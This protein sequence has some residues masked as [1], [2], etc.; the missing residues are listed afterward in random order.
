MGY[1]S[2]AMSVDSLDGDSGV[3]EDQ[4]N[5]HLAG[6]VV[7]NEALVGTRVDEGASRDGLPLPGEGG[8][9]SGWT[10]GKRGAR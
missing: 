3:Q 5:G 9:E 8:L 10:G 7:I 2:Q 4:G 6:E 1:R